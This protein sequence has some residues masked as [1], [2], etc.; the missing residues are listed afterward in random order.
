MAYG[1]DV[2]IAA[3]RSRS[4]ETRMTQTVEHGAGAQVS[5]GRCNV[6]TEGQYLVSWTADMLGRSEP[7]FMNMS[8]R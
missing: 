4:A 3:R 2:S 6:S 1:N 8:I 7:R 5:R